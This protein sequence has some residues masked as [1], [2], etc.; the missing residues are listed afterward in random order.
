MRPPVSTYR[1]QLHADFTFA[2]AQAITSYLDALG[3]TDVY[4]SPFLKASPGSLHGY[5]ITDHGRLNPE[6]G[7]EAALDAWTAGLA[8]K[9]L[10]LVLDFVPNHM[11]LDPRTNAWWRSVL[12]HGPSSQYAGYF[13]ID[14][15]PLT[16]ELD[17]RVLLP[18]LQDGYGDTLER[19]DIKLTFGNGEFGIRYFDRELPLDPKSVGVLLERAIAEAAD[20][21]RPERVQDLQVIIDIIAGLPDFSNGTAEER[22][23][24]SRISAHATE[25]LAALVSAAPA[26][27]DRIDDVVKEWTGTAGEPRS[28]DRLHDLLERQPYRLAHWR[29]AFDEINYRRFFDVNDLGGLCMEDRRVF[30][31]V[32]RLVLHLVAQGRVTGLRIDHP[33][34]LFD[35]GEY[36]RRL[37]EAARQALGKTEWASEGAQPL[38][39]AAEKILAEGETL[40]SDW[41][42]AGTTGY[43]F[44]NIVNGLFVETAKQRAVLRVYE[45]SVGRPEPFDI[46]RYRSKRL[47][48]TS[49]LASELT[50]L[51]RAL[52]QI[53]AS[54]RATRDFTLTALRRAL[55]ETVACLP[56][57]RTYVTQTGFSAADRDAIDFATDEARRRNPV[58][59]S[60]AFH[61]LRSVLL[62]E[63]ERA[64]AEQDADAWLTPRRAFAMKFQQF[65]APVEAKGVEDTAFY[66]YVPLL[67]LNE[68]GGNPARFGRSV[69]EFHA[70]NRVRLE[71]MPFEMNA[72]STH[73]TKRGEDARARIDVISELPHD[74]RHAVATWTRMNA[75][76]RTVVEREPAPDRNDEYLFY[77]SLLGA[78]P[79]ELA[80]APLP[81]EA[82]AEFVQRARRYMQ[83]ATKEAKRLTS[84]LSQ[85]SGY[86]EAVQRF[87]EGTLTG[88]SAAAFL[89][90]F[91]PF[92]RRVAAIG[93][94]NSLAQLALK[95]ASPGVADIYQGS[96]LWN[97]ALA[98]P[99]N[100]RPVD[101]EHRRAVLENICPWIVRTEQ[102]ADGEAVAGLA[103][104][105]SELMR[106]WPDGR[107]KLFVTACG[108]RLRRR[109]H[110]LFRGGSY[111]PL[112]AKGERSPN[113]VAFMRSSPR[114]RLVT[115]VPR[116]LGPALWD[117]AWPLDAQFWADTAVTL[118][119]E[120]RDTHF[121]NLLSGEIVQI[122]SGDEAP[123]IAASDVFRVSPVGLFFVAQ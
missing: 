96:E 31:D 101:F 80:D 104:Y 8:E 41:P 117:R 33:D 19:G 11:G 112:S 32:H 85:M 6:I 37:Q 106:E 4:A 40:P 36:F 56:I 35:P 2:D 53:A 95:I 89:A 102:A 91:V 109:E 9:G 84:W 42:V 26:I 45:R 86:D 87:V 108:L 22:E 88:P 120:T 23:R 48:M 97:L 1:L 59:P 63:R 51:T 58:M 54:D 114:A 76:R 5:D 123:S 52:K 92:A 15:H 61:F 69:E 20:G 55:I 79:A 118:P 73:D 47:I 12:M 122:R 10:G 39:V 113:L 17:N 105:V 66:R 71:R 64:P 14:W 16:P 82:P 116:L 75:K 90:Q 13:D 57:Y 93:M 110:E 100:R 21:S 68:V 44:M 107:I 28:F 43:G 83:K 115:I 49:S 103:G 67:S 29:T 119:R 81:A 74:W 111:E 27:R 25:Q 38:Y 94:I 121:R 70:G 3:V 18:I 62:A 50:V 77:Q 34:G 99:D 78:W 30:D 98:D 24:R 7:D 46:E 60:S 72:T 65:S